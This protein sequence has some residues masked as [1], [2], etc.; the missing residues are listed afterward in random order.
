MGVSDNHRVRPATWLL[1][2]WVL[3]IAQPASA[4]TPEKENR[5]VFDILKRNCGYCHGKI[6]QKQR[7]NVLDYDDLI[8]RRYVVPGKL[9]ESKLWIEVQSRRMP[10]D[11]ELA[12]ADIARIK[13]WIEQGSPAFLQPGESSRK[14]VGLKDT[15]K[16]VSDDLLKFGEDERRSLRYFT[17]AN[18]WNNSTVSEG[19]LL[20][21]QAAL[22]KLINSLSWE[23]EV[24][25]P[26]P[27][28]EYKTVFR[29]DL[30][31]LGWEAGDLWLQVLALY[32]YGLNYADTQL[33]EM[34][35]QVSDWTGATVPI[36]RAD[37]FIAKASMPPLYHTMLRL[38][39][40]IAELEARLGVNERDNFNRNR[41]R[42]G[43]I[44]LSEISKANRVLDRHSSRDVAY[45][46]K[47][48]DFSDSLGRRDILKYP[49]GP[50]FPK[51]PGNQPQPS[52]AFRHDGGE[53]LFS[54]P[55]GLQGYMIVNSEGKQIPVAPLEIVEMPE[56]TSR[57]ALRR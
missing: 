49:L 21:V 55:N 47:S 46:W 14:F 10:E 34:A 54:L 24:V 26:Q 3:T 20:L 33:G 16:A 41:L 56:R 7:L 31:G 1:A 42:R 51:Q 28:N 12:E 15:Y 22:A 52:S 13:D 40:T 32:P 50:E 38:P 48:F 18:M 29:V 8:K 39:F 11:G 45:Y 4:Q 27:V 44:V 30:G 25:V 6:Q 23:R 17:I 36:V 2:T 53:I 5:Q 43:G 35:Q 57:S 19:D 9:E 37:W